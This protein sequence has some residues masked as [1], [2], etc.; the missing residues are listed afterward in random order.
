MKL[1]SAHKCLY[2]A[3][4]SI[5]LKICQR[6]LIKVTNYSLYISSLLYKV[7]RCENLL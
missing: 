6:V 5:L 3:S 2:I 4:V 7:E 1:S